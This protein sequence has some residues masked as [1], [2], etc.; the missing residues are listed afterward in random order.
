VP[1]SDLTVFSRVLAWL[2]APVPGV[3]SIGGKW[4]GLIAQSGGAWPLSA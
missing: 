2:R 4:W 1:E 3:E